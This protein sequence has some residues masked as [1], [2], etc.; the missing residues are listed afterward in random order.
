MRRLAYLLL[1]ISRHV[2]RRVPF[3]TLALAGSPALEPVGRPAARLLLSTV[4]ICQAE[5]RDPPLSILR[6]R[7]AV[8]ALMMLCTPC[9]VHE[10]MLEHHILVDRCGR[11]GVL[12]VR[13]FRRD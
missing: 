1:D 10:S 9:E 8:R 2:S 4:A 5:R 3:R 7:H 6:P 11:A 13:R 12:S